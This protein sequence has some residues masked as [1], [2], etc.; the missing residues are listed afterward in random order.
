[1]EVRFPASYENDY[2]SS[3][4]EFKRHNV[5]KLEVRY[6]KN[7]NDGDDCRFVELTVP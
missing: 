3:K 2:G 4:A 5:N 7:S 1:M 6:A